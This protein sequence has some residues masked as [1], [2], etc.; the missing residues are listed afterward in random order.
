MPR[1]DLAKMNV[2]WVVYDNDNFNPICGQVIYVNRRDIM[3]NY[4]DH[5]ESRNDYD[6][7]DDDY[8]ISMQYA[9]KNLRER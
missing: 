1:A 3:K 4:K 7:Y 5:P 9:L 6:V 2:L 8:S